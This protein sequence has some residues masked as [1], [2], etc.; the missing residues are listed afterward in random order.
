MNESDRPI[1]DEFGKLLI[2]HVRD[3]TIDELK[4]LVS[5]KMESKQRKEMH[6]ALESRELEPEQFD[7]I[8]RLRMNTVETTMANFLLFFDENNFGIL[9]R[10]EEGREHDIQTMS[11]GVA[12]ELY[13][14]AGWIARFSRFKEGAA[15]EKLK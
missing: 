13:S 2:D 11:D 4:G 10:D 12:G 6:R 14:E 1:L 5:G 3:K 9:Y 15:I 7:I 8:G